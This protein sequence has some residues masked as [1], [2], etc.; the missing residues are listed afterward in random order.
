MFANGGNAWSFR[1]HNEDAVGEALQ[2]A[3][4][5]GIVRRVPPEW[6]L[7][8]IAMRVAVRRKARYALIKEISM[9]WVDLTTASDVAPG[10]V[11]AFQLGGQPIA[12]YNV[13]GDF[14]Q[15]TIFV[16]M[17]MPACPTAIWRMGGSNARC[18]RACST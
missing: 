6:E 17:L 13:E 2:E 10:E 9:P 16:R 15:R 18:I 8:R 11:K 5:K 7:V 3:I 1:Y 4:T 12:L 14:W